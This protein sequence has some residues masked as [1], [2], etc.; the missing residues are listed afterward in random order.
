MTKRLPPSVVSVCQL[1]K[2]SRQQRTGLEAH[3]R[4]VKKI[5]DQ[6]RE[7]LLAALG[8]A[9]SAICGNYVI[10]VSPGSF[11]PA[12]LSTLSGISFAASRIK[13]IILDDGTRVLGKDISSIKGSRTEKP[14]LD[15]N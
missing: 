1:Y 5:E 13:T 14:S 8:G 4:R 10:T 3:A 12:T 15:V 7:N 2:D 11:A 6:A 9:D